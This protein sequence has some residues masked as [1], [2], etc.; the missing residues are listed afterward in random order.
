MNDTALYLMWQ[1]LPH[2]SLFCYGQ[3]LANLSTIIGSGRW[4]RTILYWKMNQTSWN[5]WRARWES[6]PH[7]RSFADCTLCQYWELALWNGSI[8]SG[9]PLAAHK[10][11]RCRF[12]SLASSVATQC[13]W[14][15]I[16]GSN[17][18]PSGSEP[19]ALPIALI[20][21]KM[22]RREGNDPPI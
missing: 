18:K 4:I 10:I 11:L 1:S 13:K 15:G 12:S 5:C 16:Q 22:A 3:S 20:P 21:N 19:D 9:Q 2:G 6:D 14:L 7:W 8:A 17:L